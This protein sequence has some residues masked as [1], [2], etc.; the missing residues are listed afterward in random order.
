MLD[1]SFY[2]LCLGCFSLLSF[3]FG[4]ILSR[5]PIYSLFYL[6]C[7]FIQISVL[8]LAVG[9]DFLAF[10]LL[11]VY[12]GA[13][14]ILFLFVVMMMDINL[15]TLRQTPLNKQGFFLLPILF[16]VVF[17]CPS[18]FEFFSSDL[19]TGHYL[20]WVDIVYN[21]G[22]LYTVAS[23][24]YSSHFSSFILASYVLLVAMIGAIVV[25]LK[26]KLHVK[27]QD[28]VFQNHRNFEET[29]RRVTTVN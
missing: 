8:L 15:L 23:H 6:I 21:K 17:W 22:A 12:V 20:S 27:R 16:N 24:V 3:A 1:L 18:I 13:I 19:L 5:N 10:L 14:S 2:G 25:T 4:V 26:Q 29:I 28:V 11:M 9:I 7:V